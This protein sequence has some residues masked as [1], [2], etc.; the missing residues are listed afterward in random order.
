VTFPL[1]ARPNVVSA[2]ERS[3]LSR[4]ERVTLS[5][6]RWLNRPSRL[7]LGL[8]LWST[9]VVRALV[10]LLSSGR[11]LVAGTEHL[12]RLPADRGVLLAP[13]H[14]S[15]FDLF[16]AARIAYGELPGCRRLYF[17]V[18]SNFWYESALGLAVNVVA[19]G[20]TMYPPIFRAPSKRPVT[21]AGLDFLAS[22]LRRPGTLAGMHPEG[23]RG[24]GADPSLL[25]PP[26]AGFGRVVLSARP[27]VVPVFIDGLGNS[28][29]REAGR[30]LRGSRPI[31]VVFGA[32][33][34]LAAEGELDPS[35]LRSQI[36]I[37]REV[38]ERIGRL[39][40]RARSLA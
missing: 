1:E 5:I 2:R 34:A 40:E 6:A 35:R 10:D 32:P 31:R 38:L 39:A 12:A 13:N 26:E 15:F 29:C 7:R 23:T 22:E 21:R 17:P 20:C 11:L 30:A 28:V 9:R 3:A 8:H 18:R 16:V 25:L 36:E 19:T 4:V 27:S 14:R 33:L 37:G 24:K